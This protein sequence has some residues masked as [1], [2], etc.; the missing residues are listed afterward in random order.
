MI[1]VAGGVGRE[2]AAVLPCL[3]RGK[4]SDEGPLAIIQR[5]R[6]RDSKLVGVG[7]E[8]LHDPMAFEECSC[9]LGI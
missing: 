2:S 7:L 9:A 4:Y 1:V 5:S 3:A 8:I 6:D